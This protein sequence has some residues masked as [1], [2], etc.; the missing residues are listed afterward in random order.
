[1]VNKINTQ[2]G[3]IFQFTEL[4]PKDYEIM[5]EEGLYLLRCKLPEDDWASICKE[6]MKDELSKQIRHHGIGNWGKDGGFHIYSVAV[7]D[8]FKE[9]DEVSPLFI[10]HLLYCGENGKITL[11]TLPSLSSSS[12]TKYGSTTTITLNWN[13]SMTDF[14]ERRTDGV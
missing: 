14:G 12:I 9:T 1:M 3:P 6:D 2:T 8:N 13:V 10:L 4:T 7:S 11:N 5:P